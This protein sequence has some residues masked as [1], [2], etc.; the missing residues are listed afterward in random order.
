MSKTGYAL[1]GDWNRL[2]SFLTSGQ[3]MVDM[4]NEVIE[5]E[6]HKLRDAVEDAIPYGDAN[7]PMTVENKGFDAPL[8][9]T[10]TLASKGI[11]VNTYS[12]RDR[13]FKKY[14]VIEG[15]KRL[16][17]ATRGGSGEH[18]DITYAD[19]LEIMENGAVGAGKGHGTFI[20]PRPVLSIT[21][22]RLKSTLEKT[23]VTKAKSA[24]HEA[25]R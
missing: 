15:N 5:E 10:G 23:I 3:Q 22:D 24:I 16:T 4:V 6:A 18:N 8:F 1:T 13:G 14:F 17:V 2:R 19:L 21:F 9:E 20:P 25:I 7:A 11:V 12:S